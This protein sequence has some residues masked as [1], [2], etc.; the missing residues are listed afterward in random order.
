MTKLVNRGGGG[1]GGDARSSG[2]GRRPTAGSGWK[3][4]FRDTHKWAK[5][6]GKAVKSR[7]ARPT[8]PAMRL[9]GKSR[10]LTAA[11]VRKMLAPVLQPVRAKY[12]G[13]GLAK[14]SAFVDIADANFSEILRRLYDEHVEGFSG[15]SY[16][17][18]GNVQDAMEWRVRLKAKAERD[19]TALVKKKRESA[20]SPRGG[21][22]SRL[23][24]GDE[25]EGRTEKEKKPAVGGAR[26]SRSSAT[27]A[28]RRALE[29][30]EEEDR[31]KTIDAGSPDAREHQF[32]GGSRRGDGL[33]RMQRKKAAQMGLA[34][35]AMLALQTS[36]VKV[37]VDESARESAIEAYRAMQR[38]K[39]RS[40]GGG[41]RRR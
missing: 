17:K 33:S 4:A 24:P 13:Q 7:G 26:R 8:H 23:S 21:G 3:D 5:R 19:G 6:A 36:K 22:A 2:A 9:L 10:E 30:E 37:K 15:K 20:A 40:N 11:E 18:M 27:P 41:A 16:K 31:K 28:P 14:P 25:A 1:R 38:A 12:G 29:E 35:E 32:T 39:R 34:P